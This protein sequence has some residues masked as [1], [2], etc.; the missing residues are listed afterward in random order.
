MIEKERNVRGTEKMNEKKRAKER[1][2]DREGEREI[3]R[4]ENERKVRGIE[5]R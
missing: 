2:C 4:N 1:E 3:E 5:K